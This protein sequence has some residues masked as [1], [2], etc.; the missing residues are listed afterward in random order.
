M[1]GLISIRPVCGSLLLLLILL[2]SCRLLDRIERLNASTYLRRAERELVSSVRRAPL[3]EVP[4]VLYPVASEEASGEG[5]R[6]YET[7][8]LYGSVESRERVALLTGHPE[9]V[10]RSDDPHRRMVALAMVGDT[11]ALRRMLEAHPD[12]ILSYSLRRLTGDSVAAYRSLTALLSPEGKSLPLE[13]RRRAAWAL[14]DYPAHAAEGVQA[15]LD[16]GEQGPLREW[17]RLLEEPATGSLLLRAETPRL[18]AEV[19]RGT[20]LERGLLSALRDRLW[21]ARLWPEALTVQL[22]L[23]DEAHGAILKYRREIELLEAYE[24]PAALE[25]GPTREGRGFR[26]RF[27]PVRNVNNWAMNYSGYSPSTASTTQR[28]TADEYRRLH[29]RV[30]RALLAA[31]PETDQSEVRDRSE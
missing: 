4:V 19:S 10:L 31:N 11:T 16:L 17:L 18:L 2:S 30:T 25:E 20:L 23:P 14:T 24:R 9:E 5:A 7:A 8:R 1:R 13:V 29:D 21:E 6:L 15:L 12:P 27:G 26:E 22:R 3:R 28:L